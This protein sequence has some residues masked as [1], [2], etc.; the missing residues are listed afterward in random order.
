MPDHKV[1]SKDEWTAK[2]KELLVKEKELTRLRAQLTEA[3]QELPWVKIDKPYLFDGPAGKETLSDLF[4]GKSQLIVYHFMFQPDWTEGC[5]SC[6][7][8]ADHYE[9]AIIHLRQRDTNMVTISRAEISRIEPFRKRMG[10]E[11]K[12]VSSSQSDFNL[13]FDVSFPGDMKEQKE[14]YYNYQVMSSF[15]STEGP[16]FSVFV[17]DADG[18]I[19]HTY[20]VFARGLEQFL[21]VYDL[22]DMVPKGRNE[23]GLVYGME[24]VRHHDKYGDDSFK[25]IYVELL[26]TR[27]GNS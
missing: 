24:W 18:S 12:W 27:K 23:D 15:P 10:W 14:V 22:L 19:F 13:D 21:G 9:P 17:K 2:R 7:L 3:R 26:S 25:D 20:S 11:F 5:K 4:D 8:L 1:V 16:G 6:S